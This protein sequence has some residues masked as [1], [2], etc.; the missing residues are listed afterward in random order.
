MEKRRILI[1][2]DNAKNIQVAASILE[3][4]GFHCEF[5]MDGASGLSWL[6][7]EPFDTIL[8][9]IMMP[10]EDGFEV[11]RLIKSNEAINDIPVI[12]L[13]AKIDKE[14]VTKAFEVGG[15]DYISKPFDSKE[16]TIR[17]K[18]QVELKL[19][20]K[21]LENINRDLAKMVNEKTEKL[22]S[23]NKE[24][25]KTNIELTTKNEE[26][27]RIEDSKQ[28]FLNILG[29]EI[30]GSINEVTGM[31]QVI[32]YKVDSRKV[33]QLVDRIDH[34]MSTIETLVNA[35]LRITE[36]Q[37]QGAVLKPDKTDLN[38]LIGFA[39]FQLDNKIRR[40]QQRIINLSNHQVCYATGETQ[41]LMAAMIII[42]D[43]F[44]ERNN[45]DSSITI[46]TKSDN[47][48]ISIMFYDS[49]Q[50]VTDSEISDIFDTF[51]TESQSL[52][53][54]K[55]IAEAHLGDITIKNRELEKGIELVFN[56][57]KTQNLL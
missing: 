9:D 21:K 39:M 45:Y 41:L 25:E 15:A 20:R 29:N 5:A 3:N 23:I 26:L 49:G 32:K 22:S 7:S 1:I 34:S 30:S 43:F 13:T 16:L 37:S 54:A 6:E 47:E 33:A 14:S 8:L 12:F 11:C 38:K 44:I 48:K 51:Y 52:S 27:Q 28:N 42:L 31:L 35:A 24:L 10:G 56:L 4:E 46:K 2:D 36:L 57:N 55:L 17:V 18:N 40:K 19:S 53:F 50:H